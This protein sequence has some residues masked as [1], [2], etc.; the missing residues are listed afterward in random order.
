MTYIYIQLNNGDIVGAFE[1]KSQALHYADYA[2]LEEGWK[3]VNG[4]NAEVK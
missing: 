2:S 1:T 4:N 3:L